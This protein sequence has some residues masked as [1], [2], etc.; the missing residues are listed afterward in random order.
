MKL[1][2]LNLN[3]WNYNEWDIRKPKIIK[4]IQKHKP[5]FI[6]FQEI[7]DDLKFNKKGDNQLEQLNKKLNYPYSAFYAVTDKRNER[8]TK[9]KRYCIEGIGV[10][11]KFPILKIEKKK[12]KKHKEDIYNCGNLHIKIKANK[13]VDLI[14][15][16]FSNSNYF[17]LLHLLETL[18]YIKNKKIKPVILGDFNMY[19]S[20]VLHDLT[21]DNFNN[22]REYKKYISYPAR[23]WTLD[24]ILIPKNCKFK[25]FKS[26]G[27]GLS[28][29]KVLISSINI[30]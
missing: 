29:H 14:V 1:K 8:P 7:R 10:L 19:E 23:K 28:D 6:A 12:L 26:A 5:D 21:R 11:S 2:L 15:V 18:N 17:S 22:S 3:L 20:D 30:K 27:Y 24:Y 16:H 9:Y 13:I 25:S 4:F